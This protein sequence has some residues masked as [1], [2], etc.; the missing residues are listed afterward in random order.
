MSDDSDSCPD[1][2]EGEPPQIWPA[3][4]ISVDVIENGGDWTAIPE[5]VA[6]VRVAAEAAARVT[7]T[8]LSGVS[9][10][11]VLSDDAEVAALN[12]SYRGKASSTNVLS[13]PARQGLH[14]S[15]QQGFIG[16]IILAA[17]TV[18]REAEDLAVPPRHHF[19]HLIVHALL[20]LSGF[21][22]DGEA[23]AESMEALETRILATLAI[24]DPYAGAELE[25]RA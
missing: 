20:H 8:G 7:E 23:A 1:G 13:F 18:M 19:Q 3:G 16:D 15:G 22:H 2:T 24:P 21:D 11:V 10:A 4:L 5:V 25:T 12:A 6:A 17:E 14:A 9:A